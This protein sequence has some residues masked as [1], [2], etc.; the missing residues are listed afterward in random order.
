MGETKRKRIKSLLK[1]LIR[2]K[3]DTNSPE[4]KARA[5]SL[6]KNVREIRDFK[7]VNSDTLNTRF[8]T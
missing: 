2:T 3:V 6:E 8:D 1:K 7:K 4:F 5:K